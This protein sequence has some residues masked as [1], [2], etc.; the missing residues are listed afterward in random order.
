MIPSV[1]E[2]FVFVRIDLRI[3]DQPAVIRIGGLMR[4]SEGWRIGG[5]IDAERRGAGELVQ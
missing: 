1:E 3:D 4:I 2:V 5:R